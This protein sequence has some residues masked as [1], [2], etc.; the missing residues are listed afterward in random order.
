MLMRARNSKKSGKDSSK[1]DNHPELLEYVQCANPRLKDKLS[2][3]VPHLKKAIHH[4]GHHRGN[5]TEVY[6]RVTKLLHT[7]NDIC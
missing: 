2:G 7:V 3:A 5:A 1:C 6:R 4:G